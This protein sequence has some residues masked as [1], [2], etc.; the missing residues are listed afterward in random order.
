MFLNKHK[1]K[2]A[3]REQVPSSTPLVKGSIAILSKILIA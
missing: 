2:G 1:K 3:E